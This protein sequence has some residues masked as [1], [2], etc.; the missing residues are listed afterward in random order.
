[1]RQYLYLIILI[2]GFSL[3]FSQAKPCCKNKA[4]IEKV[5]CKINKD[6]IKNNENIIS[7]DKLVDKINCQNNSDIN[8][9]QQKKCNGCNKKSQWWMFWKKQDG[10]LNTKSASND[11]L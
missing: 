2:L 3:G 9:L 6:D 1:M 8:S 11:V 4:G 10:C 7:N 5:S